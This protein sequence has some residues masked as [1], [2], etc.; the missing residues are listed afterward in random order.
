[1]GSDISPGFW[2][3]IL[4][5]PLLQCAIAACEDMEQRLGGWA[6][7]EH[8]LEALKH[9]LWLQVGERAGMREVRV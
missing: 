8:G 9:A 4:G 5:V 6:A 7:R 1:M 3:L 2:T